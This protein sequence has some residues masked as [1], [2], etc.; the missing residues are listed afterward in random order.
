[1][2]DSES[3][4]EEIDKQDEEKNDT[5]DDEKRESKRVGSKNRQRKSKLKSDSKE[6]DQP[7]K[8]EYELQKERNIAKNQALLARIKDP[9]FQ[10]AMEEIGK[11]AP[12][13]K[14]NKAEKPQPNPEERRTSARLSSADGR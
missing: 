2:N 12:A 6:G 8:S 7:K 1:M 3:Q 4:G 13:K 11:G 14:K 5:V 9:E 10:A